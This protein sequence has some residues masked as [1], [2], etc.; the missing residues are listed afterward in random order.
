VRRR[1]KESAAETVEEAAQTFTQITEINRVSENQASAAFTLAM[2]I[3]L[4]FMI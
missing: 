4:E 2:M 1:A 3:V